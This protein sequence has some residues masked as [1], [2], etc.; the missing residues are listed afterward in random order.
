VLGCSL[1]SFI[2]SILP[3]DT[4]GLDFALTA[5]FIVLLVEQIKKMHRPEPYIAGLI[6]CVV[7][8]FLVS[9][10]DFLLV[11]LVISVV[12]LILLRPRLDTSNPSGEA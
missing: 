12:F 8:L 2:G 4:K 10:R 11:S 7:S 5:L 6:A 9:S 3:F 1:G